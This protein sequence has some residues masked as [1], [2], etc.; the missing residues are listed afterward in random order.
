MNKTDF[1][2]L[3]FYNENIFTKKY[4][5][6][7]II[8]IKYKEFNNIFKK[9]NI[10][11]KD[12]YIKNKPLMFI[13]S[14]KGASLFYNLFIGAKDNN[15]KVISRHNNNRKATDIIKELGL[16]FEKD[17]IIFENKRGDITSTF[18]VPKEKVGI[19]LFCKDKILLVANKSDENEYVWGIPKGGIGINESK[20][21][22]AMREFKEETGV[23]PDFKS[24][25]PVI[26]KNKVTIFPIL[27]ETLYDLEDKNGLVDK[28]EIHGVQWVDTKYAIKELK[29]STYKGFRQ[30]L[31]SDTHST[32]EE[33]IKNQ[34]Q[35]D[36]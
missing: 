26:K 3:L 32:I 11:E 33:F 6:E 27:T 13:Y 36:K 22:G 7:M 9:Y 28:N 25:G 23:E 18:K 24:H 1:I 31:N 21:E 2:D 12:V 15:M 8:S 5:R 17:Y 19:S 30:R 35:F 10:S 16:L 29:D 4:D 14:H 20:W 34:I